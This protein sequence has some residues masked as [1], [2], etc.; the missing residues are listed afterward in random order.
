MFQRVEKVCSGEGKM[1][2]QSSLRRQVYKYKSISVV[3][4]YEEEVS[5][6]GIS[7]WL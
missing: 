6:P 5:S 7:L 1:V 4:I 3:A 2:G